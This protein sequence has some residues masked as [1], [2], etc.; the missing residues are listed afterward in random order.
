MYTFIIQMY[1]LLLLT[2]IV[3]NVT[4]TVSK[5]VNYLVNIQS[6]YKKKKTL[7]FFRNLLRFIGPSLDVYNLKEY[8]ITFYIKTLF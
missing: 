7:Y 4:N 2:I 3:F 5:N 6:I 8:F 1:T